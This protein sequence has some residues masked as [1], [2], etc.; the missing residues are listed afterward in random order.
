MPVFST[1]ADIKKAIALFNKHAN[2]AGF[3]FKVYSS[4]NHC[5]YIQASFDF[6]YYVNVD[7]EC[8]EVYYTNIDSKAS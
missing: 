7:L 4:D 3:E 2:N 6:A 8:R 5:L 1:Y